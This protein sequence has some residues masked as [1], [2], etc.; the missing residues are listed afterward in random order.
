MDR[1]MG[2]MMDSF[3]GD[4]FEDGLKRLK[5]HLEPK[6]AEHKAA[7]DKADVEATA[8]AAAAPA[9]ANK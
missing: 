7:K 4:S 2:V 6:Y 8:A 9:A 3:V 5:A 1:Y